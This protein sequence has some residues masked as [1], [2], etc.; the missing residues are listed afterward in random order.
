M[1]P[2]IL[3]T[4]RSKDVCV[5]GNR[6][7]NVTWIKCDYCGQWLHLMCAKLAKP[8]ISKIVKYACD[9]CFSSSGAITSW[10]CQECAG[11]VR[12]SD[13]G[14][15]LGCVR[16]EDCEKRACTEAIVE[17]EKEDTEDEVVSRRKPVT[18]SIMGTAS[19]SNRYP[20]TSTTKQRASVSLSPTFSEALKAKKS[21]KHDSSPSTSASPSLDHHF[22]APMLP[23]KPKPKVEYYD[24]FKLC[25]PDGCRCIRPVKTADSGDDDEISE[26][27]ADESSDK[28]AV[29]DE[30]SPQDPNKCRQSTCQSQKLPTS[31]YCSGICWR[32]DR[33]RVN[34]LTLY[35]IDYISSTLEK[36]R[37]TGCPNHRLV[38]SE[39]CSHDCMVLAAP[40]TPRPIAGNPPVEKISDATVP[41]PN[42]NIETPSPKPFILNVS[43]ASYFKPVPDDYVPIAED[44]ILP[45]AVIKKPRPSPPVRFQPME[46]LSPRVEI[47]FGSKKPKET[48]T[49]QS[50]LIL[51]KKSFTLPAAVTT[52]KKIPSILPSGD[53]KAKCFNLL[54]KNER[55]GQ[56]RYCSERCLEASCGEII[57]AY[58]SLFFDPMKDPFCLVG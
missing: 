16:K 27:V 54:C 18:R 9:Q 41:E 52:P 51:P 7:R 8:D 19:T 33:K 35:G 56:S 50:C 2:S 57:K 23:A 48:P 53:K 20:I 38:N 21:D 46:D 24:K 15:C 39:F 17:S 1:Q 13:C 29:D 58:P 6:R 40:E 28:I 22:I 26:K 14:H 5:C 3:K 12:T 11:C 32:K 30:N 45:P 47:I 10:R 25:N 42:E 4:R 37:L 31:D 44:F 55:H 34:T 49:P 36:C 43:D